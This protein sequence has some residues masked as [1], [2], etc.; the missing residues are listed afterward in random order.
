MNFTYV[1]AK[2]MP[3]KCGAFS[4]FFLGMAGWTMG[5]DW[6][7]IWLTSFWKYLFYAL[8]AY[9]IGGR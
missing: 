9:F 5:L 8:S 4:T 7:D 2:G 6:Q 3:W 1:G